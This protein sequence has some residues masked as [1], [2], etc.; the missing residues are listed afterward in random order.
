MTSE[1]IRTDVIDEAFEAEQRR[2]KR[3]IRGAIRAGYDGVDLDYAPIHPSPPTITPWRYPAPEEANGMQ[4]VRYTW[5]WF[6]DE[7]LTRIL[8][9]R[10]KPLLRR[11]NDAE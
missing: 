5:D 6:S 1:S 8:A 9:F 4:T 3:A 7:G 10:G 2:I 11:G